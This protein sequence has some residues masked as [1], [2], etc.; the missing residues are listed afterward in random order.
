M[1]FVMSH[2]EFS[3]LNI[4]NDFLMKKAARVGRPANE[5]TN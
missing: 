4:H 5:W 3:L 2:V 1:H